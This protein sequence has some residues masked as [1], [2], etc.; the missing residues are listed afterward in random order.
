MDPPSEEAHETGEVA[1]DKRKT[2]PP[3][4]EASTSKRFRIIASKD[5][6][7]WSLPEDLASYCNEHLNSFF[8]KEDL[9]ENHFWSI[10][11]S[12]ESD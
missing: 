12:M 8:S 5:Q 4:E 3:A 10:M 2:D 6:C 1:G 9:E 7:K 11:Q